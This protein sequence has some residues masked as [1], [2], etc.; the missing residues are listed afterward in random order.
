MAH[1]SRL[2]TP[3]RGSFLPEQKREQNRVFRSRRNVAKD[4]I[5]QETVHDARERLYVSR[6]IGE[7]RVE[8]VTR[9]WV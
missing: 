2:V 3:P 8:F 9:E 7:N 1:A 4:E 5:R 6:P